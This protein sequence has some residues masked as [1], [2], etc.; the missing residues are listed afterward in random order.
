M[1]ISLTHIVQLDNYQNNLDCLE[2]KPDKNNIHGV[3]FNPIFNEL[4]YFHVCTPGL[5]PCL[6]HA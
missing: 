3:K 6:G 4:Q 2:N 1:G 5:P